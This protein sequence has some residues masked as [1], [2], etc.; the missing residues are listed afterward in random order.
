MRRRSVSRGILS[1]NS[2]Q[3]A[4][5]LALLA[6]GAISTQAQV[7][8]ALSDQV[9]QW[10]G[11]N[12]G[13]YNQYHQFAKQRHTPPVPVPPMVDPPCHICGDT[14]QTQGEA[15]VAAWV[16]QSENPENTYITGLL[17]MDKQ[18]QLW[19]GAGS[20]HLTPQAQKALAQFEDDAGFM[21]DAAAIAA[22]LVNQKAVPMAQRYDKEPKQAYAGITFLLATVREEALLGNDQDHAVENHALEMAEQW[23]DS[24]NQKIQTDVLS[25][26]K[27]NLC[28]VYSEIVRAVALLGGQEPKDMAQYEQMLK[29]LQDLV[30]F[31]VSLNLKVAIDN[32]DGS[33]MHSTWTGKAKLTLNLDLSNSCYTPTFDNGGKMAVTVS[34]FDMINIET[35]PNGSKQ[36]I[37]VTLT[38]SHSYNATLGSPQ[39]NLCDPQPIFQ[40]PMPSSIPP[41]ELTAKGHKVNSNLFGS[42]IGA[43]VATNELNTKATNAVTGGAPS[44][45]GQSK[46]SQNNGSSGKGAGGSSSNPQI[47]ALK[48][49]IQQHKGDPNWLLSSQG[50]AVIAQVQ[51]QA[52]Q[53]AQS[54]MASAGVV[55]PTATSLS[56]LGQ[57][58]SSAHLPWTNGQSEPVNKTLHVKKDTTDITL[59][60]T[61]QQASQ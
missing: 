41:E 20:D 44:L 35:E 43:V 27:Y 11:K 4:V 1:L 60:V 45:P 58:L 61:V 33:F 57:T 38:S 47:D 40:M 10:A 17:A 19:G 5:L 59:T 52:L 13:Q 56:Q 16:T 7:N 2:I 51:Q 8:A 18:I 22:E 48:A 54:K 49:E 55:A 23:E 53:Q 26:H 32:A 42:F 25:G 24:I 31:N 12:I 30:K 9:V 39:L 29:K 46:P 34:G 50:Q 21:S 36:K 37:P 15:Q 14:T 6:V 3:L 28:P